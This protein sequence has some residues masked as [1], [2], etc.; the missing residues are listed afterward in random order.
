[1]KELSNEDKDMM[2]QK[3][4]ETIKCTCGASL[5]GYCKDAI[6]CPNSINQIN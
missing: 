5:T 2:E 3:G 6:A 4:I 1:M